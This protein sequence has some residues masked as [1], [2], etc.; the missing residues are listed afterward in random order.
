LKEAVNPERKGSNNTNTS[1]LMINPDDYLNP[2]SIDKPNAL[3]IPEQSQ[4][5]HH[6][7]VHT[8]NHPVS[9]LKGYKIAIVGLPDDRMSSNSGS[10]LAPDAIRQALYPMARIPGKLKIA[11]LGNLKQG[12]SFNDTIAGLTDILGWLLDENIFT[13]LIGGSSAMVKAIDKYFSTRDLK[14][15][16]TSVDSKIDFNADR[17]EADACNYL[18][19]LFRPEK[20]SLS[21]FTNIGHQ[22]YLNDPQSIN[23]LNRKRYDLMRVGDV[24][25]AIHLTE[26]LLR[27]TDVIIFD[28]GVVRQSDAPGTFMPSPNGLY[29]EE[30]CLIARFSGVSDNLKVFG[31]F[32]VNPL[33]DNNAQTTSLAAQILWF[34]LESYA[35]KQVENPAV[36]SN[37]GRFTRYHITVPDPGVE[38]VFVKSNF[39]DRWW[40][41]IA[42]S[43]GKNHYVSCSYEDYL[44]ANSNEI[45]ERWI[46]ASSRF[47]N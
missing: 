41:E 23:R 13:I 24:R 16:L 8:E 10:S 21:H 7:A 47:G 29:G 11:D 28:I 27:D 14:Y 25:Q 9:S 6:I 42:S 35:Q 44:K 31:L 43:A 39:T 38:M 2:V 5:S 32:E 34:L 37:S 22:I 40:I 33:K 4:F 20:S 26:P 36:T 30:S 1:P 19:T 17:K 18:S 45:P 46:R 15:S 12:V 3:Y